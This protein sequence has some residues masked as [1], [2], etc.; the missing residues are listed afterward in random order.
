MLIAAPAWSQVQPSLV[1]PGAL[2]RQEAERRRYLDEQLQPARPS[3]AVIRDEQPTAASRPAAGGPKFILTSVQFGPSVFLRAEELTNIARRYEG[4]E[5]DFS[6][7]S[8]LVDEINALYREH[9]VLTGRAILSAQKI[10]NNIVKIDLV[11]ARLAAIK[12]EGTTYTRPTYVS[13]WIMS[14]QDQILD[15]GRLE[16]RIRRFNRSSD[17]QLEAS[18][19]PGASFGL[20]DVL[21]NVREP[22]HYQLRTF[23]NNEGS[24]SVGRE[25]VGFDT[26]VNGPFGIGDRASAYVSHSRGATSGFLSY[27][28]P[29]NHF[30][31]RLT[32]TYNAGVTSVVAGPYRALGIEGKSKSVQ[33]GLIQPVW[34]GGAWW[35]DLVS[36]IGKTF[37]DNQIGVQPLSRTNI[38]SQAIGATA[39]GAFEQRTLNFSFTASHAKQ[40]TVTGLE[41]DFNVRQFSGSW[42]ET[43][44]DKQYGV[45][46]TT[47]QDTNSNILSPS[48]LFQLGGIGSVRGYEVGALSGDRGYLI[49]GE[50]HR[51]LTQAIDVYVFQDFGEVRTEGLPHQTAR[52]VGFGSD[53]QWG[54]ALRSNITAGYTLNQVQPDQHKWRITARVSYEF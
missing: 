11:E 19:R 14:Q 36:T 40:S 28:V 1:D 13:N 49:N 8:V 25:Q 7:L 23:V 6:A 18:L 2:Q 16:D 22:A 45:I 48:L 12:V 39:S 54:S 15:T 29:I 9:G 4:S 31:G 47:I 24:A 42:I 26:T 41:R 53:L 46:R 35:L 38:L 52:S 30:G 50:F 20:T 37:S 17:V 3:R 44:G 32:G 33:L 5:V 43:L 21:L 34:Q 51:A 10:E 27:A